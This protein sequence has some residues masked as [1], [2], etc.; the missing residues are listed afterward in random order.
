MLGKGTVQLYIDFV[1]TLGQSYTAALR[2]ELINTTTC[3]AV[4]A[5][6][7][8]LCVHTSKTFKITQINKSKID[9]LVYTGVLIHKLHNENNISKT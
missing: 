7:G 4:C 3:P 5:A 1:H 6:E 9:Q 2:H 8:G